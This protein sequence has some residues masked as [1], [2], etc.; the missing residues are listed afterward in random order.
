MKKF[1]TILLA[2][3][4]IMAL[5]VPAFAADPETG[6]ITVKQTVNGQSYSIYQMATLDS[7]DTVKSAYLYT[8]VSVWKAFF[9]GYA[10]NNADGNPVYFEY[11][12]DGNIILKSD[13]TV[14][15]AAFAKDA[16]AYAAETDGISAADAKT[17]D[18]TDVVFDELAL[19]YYLV[20]S[21]L[22]AFC[23]LTTTAP[24]AEVN[25]KNAAPTIDKFVEE[26]SL[27]DDGIADNEWGKE[28]DADM[29]QTINYKTI[30]TV[31]T[32]AMNYVLHDKME[33]GLTWDGT[34]TVTVDGATVDAGEDT[35]TLV[36]DP[37][38]DCTFK[39]EFADSYV[40]SLAA[41]KQIL[42]T[43][44]AYL[45][46]NAEIS[47]ETNDNETWLGYGDASE[48]SHITTQTKVYKFDFVKTD[49][50]NNV[51][52]GAKFKLYDAATAGNEIAVVKVSDG[53]YRLAKAGET[54][55]EI[56]TKNGV[57]TVIGFDGDN[58]K[59]YIEETVA[60]DGYNKLTARQ[61]ITVADQN[62]DSVVTDG[63]W[64]SGVQIINKTGSILPET[65]GF[66][67]TMFILMG[68]AI[69]LSAGVLLFAKK[70]MSQIAE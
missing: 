4:M 10:E 58:G 44:S 17:S 62:L 69:V 14:D 8:P 43:Y 34:V 18:G 1:L 63:K 50:E 2:V 15:A 12:A 6:S 42:V 32:G 68:G 29:F 49:A 27:V 9:D 66:G 41:G 70:R 51:L 65:G 26:D 7:Y 61:E 36:A 57:A 24:D 48:T 28:N 59:Y 19:G 21:S 13:V 23:G 47:T 5:A 22:G 3:M 33:A 37:T 25:E 64:V 45:N 54:G 55:V 52:D 35:Y 38:D 40:Q 16:L 56:E 53:V 20:D 39:I 30:V 67:K 60:P 11:N 31:Q 46:E